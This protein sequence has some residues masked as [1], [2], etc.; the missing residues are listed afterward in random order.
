MNVIEKGLRKICLSVEYL[1][2]VNS[3][4]S[5]HLRGVVLCPENSAHNGAGIF[6]NLLVCVCFS[7]KTTDILNA[8]S[9]R[10]WFI[11]G[12]PEQVRLEDLIWL[13]DSIDSN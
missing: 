10:P 3:R 12:S 1:F 5:G 9:T 13:H 11:L 6:V 4:Y 8:K 7:D 2:T